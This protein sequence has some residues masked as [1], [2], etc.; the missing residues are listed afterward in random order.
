MLGELY[1][2]KG[3]ALETAQA[4]LEIKNP[5]ACNVAMGCSNKCLYCVSGDT[6]VLMGDLTTKKIKNVK[7]GDKIIGL[8]KLKNKQSH[9]LKLV[10]TTV[11][12]KFQVRKIPYKIYLENGTI[13]ICSDEHRWLTNRGWKY[14]IGK[15]QGRKRRKYLTCQNK[16]RGTGSLLETP[17]ITEDYMKGYLSGMIRGDGLLKKYKVIRKKRKSYNEYVY[18]FRLALIDNNAI[19]RVKA[20]LNFFGIISSNFKFFTKN[21]KSYLWAIRTSKKEYFYKLHTLIAINLSSK[22]WQRGFMAGFFD[23]EGTFSG[24]LRICNTDDFLLDLYT[25]CARNLGFSFKKEQYIDKIKT[26]ILTGGLEKQIKFFNLID[27]AIKR[28]TIIYRNRLRKN[29]RIKSIK[30]GNKRMLMYDITTGTENYIANGMVSHNCYGDTSNR[31]WNNMKG[32]RLPKYNSL[33]L[34]KKQIEN[35]MKP[36]GVFLSF[37]TD[38]FI[39][40]N[41]ENSLDLIKFLVLKKIR[42]ATLSKTDVPLIKNE[43]RRGMT[44]VSSDDE[45]SR[46]FEPNA[47]PIS[48]RIEALQFCHDYGGYTWVSLEPYPTPEI[49]RQNLK[50]LLDKIVFVDFIVFGK[51]NYDI[52]ANNPAFYKK[53]VEEFRKFCEERGIRHHI[54]SETLKFIGEKNENN[55]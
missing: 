54:K 39:K 23:A 6:L 42:I 46:R 7:I 31:R 32:V 40:E 41:K 12:N 22:E 24:N 9:S 2:P 11:L 13:L 5:M 29:F 50:D 35:G 26:I 53:T 55:S 52:R 38:P 16:I 17:K 25:K 33:E 27:N 21:T 18:M 30:K 1:K 15:M 34:V 14:T 8:N 28:K 3:K 48:K 51:W 47:M 19:K 49:W 36:E 37:M 43:V 4:V 45:F 44:I 10:K 20:Y